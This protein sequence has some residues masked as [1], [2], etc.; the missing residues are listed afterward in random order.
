[1]FAI[2]IIGIVSI[3]NIINASLCERKQEFRILHSLGATKGNINKILIY[4]DIYM[5]L[6]ATIIS[7]II[8]IPILII[9]IKYME[10]I[11]IFNKLLIP[12]ANIT[13]FFIIILLTLII[14]TLLSHKSIKQK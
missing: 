13:L 2:I 12:F 3:I 10:N 8:S 14:I 1:M 11:I 9:I 4:E 5:F 6:K 7:I